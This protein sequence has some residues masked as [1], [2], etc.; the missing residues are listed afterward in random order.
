MCL[1]IK[2]GKPF[3]QYTL[4]SLVFSPLHSIIN[5][6]KHKS[7]STINPA[8]MENM[9]Q[10]IVEVHP[11]IMV[12][13]YALICFQ[14]FKHFRQQ[15]KQR[16]LYKAP[17]IALHLPSFAP[18]CIPK[19]VTYAAVEKGMEKKESKGKLRQNHNASIEAVMAGKKAHLWTKQ[20]QTVQ[21][22]SLQP[23]RFLSNA[24][25]KALVSESVSK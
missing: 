8:I 1:T 7:I 10:R 6:E 15:S 16:I 3:H 22:L 5:R 12:Y 14:L 19:I 17:L 20:R 2:S 25:L 24:C 21:K 13:H 23:Q 18:K 9:E 4:Y 11:L